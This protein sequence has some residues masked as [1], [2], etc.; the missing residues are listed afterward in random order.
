MSLL[1][2]IGDAAIKTVTA[3][4]RFVGNVGK[5]AWETASIVGNVVTGDLASAKKNMGELW[6]ATKGAAFS[7]VESAFLL[8]GGVGAVGAS[9]TLGAAATS[10]G[11]KI[12]GTAAVKETAKGVGGAF[13]T[14]YAE[15]HVRN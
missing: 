11:G 9:A 3:P 7:G 12:L 1:S 13:A 14:A 15:T 5:M 2:K 8:A 6:D 10:M 4:F